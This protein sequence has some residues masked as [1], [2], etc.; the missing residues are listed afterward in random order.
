MR[1]IVILSFLLILIGCNS[2]KKELVSNESLKELPSLIKV[3]YAEGFSIRA[4]EGYKILTINEAWKDAGEIH[5]YVLYE[6]EKPVNVEGATFIKVPISS[7]AC[8]SLTHVAFLEKLELERSIVGISGCNYV[9]SDKIKAEITSGEIKEIGQDQNISYEILLENSPDIIMS[10]G[11]NSTSSGSLNKMNEL[12]LK[13]VLNS[14]Y[15]ET[16]PLGKAEWIKFVAAFYNKSDEA[17]FI[18]NNIERE[19]LSL[20]GL[21]NNI[22]VKPT[23]FTGMPWSGSWYVPGGSS[24]QSRLFK[25]AG[26]KYLWTNNSEKSSLVKSKE[27]IID[28]AYDADFWLNLNSYSTIASVVDFDNKF[29]GFSS[30]KEKQLFNNDALLNAKGG[31]HYW[32]SGVINPQLILKDLIEIFHPDLIDHKLY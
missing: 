18:F 17:N 3:K 27:I 10:Y 14:E 24:F 16:H 21:T 12:G 11:I 20:L 15:M 28:E 8:M 22:K 6:N 2:E 9:S 19:Y 13:V 26:A 30:V 23:V 7:I 32:E 29:K 1:I 5:K 25:D 4:F 31:N